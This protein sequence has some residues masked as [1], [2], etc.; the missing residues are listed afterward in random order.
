MKKSHKIL[1]QKQILLA[2]MMC[3]EYNDEFIDGYESDDCNYE[4]EFDNDQ[5]TVHNSDFLRKMCKTYKS[6]R[7]KI[8]RNKYE[9]NHN[10][11]DILYDQQQLDEKTR[12]V[13]PLETYESIDEFLVNETYVNP[14]KY[15]NRKVL[16]QNS[17]QK[18]DHPYHWS[19]DLYKD[20]QH[21]W[22]QEHTGLFKR[23]DLSKIP[24]KALFDERRREHH[25]Y[26]YKRPK[27]DWSNC[28]FHFNSKQQIN[29]LITALKNQHVHKCH[30]V[31]NQVIYKNNNRKHLTQCDCPK[32]PYCQEV[33]RVL[34]KNQH[35]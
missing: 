33:A 32:H 18:E 23:L 10:K 1:K 22:V 6:Q 3:L 8:I 5:C 2:A 14:N 21:D 4:D 17:G 35:N 28:Q 16:N 29:V 30:D 25:P 20:L 34:E 19:D 26:V 27:K 31:Q 11:S 7:E 12:E 24:C 15:M 9:F 13:H